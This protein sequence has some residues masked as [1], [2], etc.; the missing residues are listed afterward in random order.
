MNLTLAVNANALGADFFLK[1]PT[2]AKGV[3]TQF[4][5]VEI[6]ENQ[7]KRVERRLRHYQ[8]SFLQPEISPSQDNELVLTQTPIRLEVKTDEVLLESLAVLHQTIFLR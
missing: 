3:M 6:M 7:L 5:A 4:S 2:L 8:Q 1:E